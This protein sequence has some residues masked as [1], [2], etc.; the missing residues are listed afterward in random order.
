MG[1]HYG[2]EKIG[3]TVVPISGGQTRRQVRMMKDLGT[4]LLACTP[5]YALYIAETMAEMG[6]T[7]RDLQLRSGV[8]GA[9]PWSENMRSVI[10]ERLGINAYDIYGLSEII[11]PGVA[12]ECPAKDGL[13]FSEDHF[14]AEII[15][16]ATGEVLPEGATGELVFTTITK[17]ALPLVRYRT[18]DI[19]SLKRQ[20][21]PCGR[22]HTRMAKVSGR[23]DDMLI[24]R[25][26]NVFPSQVESILLEIGQTAPHY[27]LVVDRRGSLDTLEI[28]VEVSEQMFSDKVKG[29]EQLEK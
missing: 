22:T 3:A 28:W 8:F 23:S 2:A 27:Q 7:P 13:H 15:D 17:E 10:E 1:V 14:I 29:L 20:P 9:E 5:S 24:I 19:T 25:G 11:G 6:L 21:C 16:P 18:R 26:V 12:Y 4:T